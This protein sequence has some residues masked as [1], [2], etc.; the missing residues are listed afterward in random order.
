[1]L[2]STFSKR[3]GVSIDTLRYYEKIGLI[4][5]PGRDK[6][7]NRDY[8]DDHLQWMAFLEILKS[9]GM[10]VKA[11]SRYVALRAEGASSI[12]ERL[13]MLKQH[14]ELVRRERRR[15]TEIDHLLADKI[16]QFQAVVDGVMDPSQLTC[17][18]GQ[19]R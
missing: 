10:S 16:A 7:G 18:Q 11:M 8:A 12:A 14:H 6:G 9:T 15:L 13:R 4:P 1:M 17:D 3:T 19:G 2:I 5:V